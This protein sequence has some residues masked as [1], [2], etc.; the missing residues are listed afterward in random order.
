MIKGSLKFND[1]KKRLQTNQLENEINFLEEND[2][3]VDSLREHYKDFIKKK[4]LIFKSQQSFRSE[5]HNVVNKI[6]LRA[7][8]NKIIKSIDSI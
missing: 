4:G 2:I 5:K 6:N 7:S 1:Y 8:N 3:E